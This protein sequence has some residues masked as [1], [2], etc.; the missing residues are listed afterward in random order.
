MEISCIINDNNNKYVEQPW[1]NRYKLII[2]PA[3]FKYW[4]SRKDS[5]PP[6]PPESNV[7]ISVGHVSNSTD[8][9]VAVTWPPVPRVV[10][11]IEGI[12]EERRLIGVGSLGGN[13]ITWCLVNC[14]FCL[15]PH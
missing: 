4:P 9:A 14:H 11:K 10:S 1:R 12:H 15:R 6:P 8:S 13:L 7:L 3:P 2:I 5:L